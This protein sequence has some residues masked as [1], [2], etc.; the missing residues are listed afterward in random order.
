MYV[1]DDTPV[2]L[3]GNVEYVVTAAVLQ[4]PGH[5]FCQVRLHYPEGVWDWWTHDDL[6]GGGKLRRNEGGKFQPWD[7]ICTFIY[8]RKR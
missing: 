6:S 8:S 3:L 2:V 7:W 5:L 1:V 4:E